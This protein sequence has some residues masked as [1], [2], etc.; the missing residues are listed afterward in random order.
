MT[1]QIFDDRGFL[2][3]EGKAFVDDGFTKEVK[4]IFATAA[5]YGDTLTVSCILK[6]IVSEHATNHC[7][8]ISKR[9]TPTPPEPR[10][11]VIPFPQRME[12]LK[13]VQDLTP[14]SLNGLSDIPPIEE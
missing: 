5:S 11:K 12:P 10:A 3:P 9:A 4:R 8:N 2:T 6:S 14:P 7:Y 1:K 13:S